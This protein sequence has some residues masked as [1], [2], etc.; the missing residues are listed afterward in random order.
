MTKQEI[1]KLAKQMGEDLADL[2][3]GDTLSA[4]W[5]FTPNDLSHYLGKEF[6]RDLLNTFRELKKKDYSNKEIAR[7]FEHPTLV[8]TYLTYLNDSDLS[9]EER[10]ELANQIFEVLKV[11]RKD[12]YCKGKLNILQDSFVDKS[13]FS[14]DFMKD[15]SLTNKISF[16]LFMYLELI[17]PTSMRLGYSFHGPYE[18]KGERYWVKDYFHLKNPF[19]KEIKDFPYDQIT[20]VEKISTNP[21]VDFFNHLLKIPLKK[22]SKV[23]VNGKEIRNLENFLKELE[24]NI[25]TI[26]NKLSKKTRKEWLIFFAHG[27][28]YSFYPL[29]K[30]LNKKFEI[31]QETLKRIKEEEY[32]FKTPQNEKDSKKI[33]KDFLSKVI[34]EGFCKAFGVEC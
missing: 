9:N 25:R 32:Y 17:Y 31:P 24:E 27:L 2:H 30:E 20:I 15:I 34:F 6:C 4:L 18:E 28:Y 33:S 5:P 12:P 3:S 8:T 14:K 29:K 13:L 11:V 1:I 19:I 22:A 21:K 16:L 10:F 7:L 23:L 26:I